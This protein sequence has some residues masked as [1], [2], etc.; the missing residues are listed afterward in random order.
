[1]PHRVIEGFKLPSDGPL[2]ENERLWIEILRIIWN[3]RVPAPDHP[4]VVALRE[5]AAARR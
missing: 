1:M 4:T 2:S 5:W 3:D